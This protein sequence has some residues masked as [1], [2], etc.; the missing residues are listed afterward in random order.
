M[1]IYIRSVHQIFTEILN[2]GNDYYFKGGNSKHCVFKELLGWR[3][4]HELEEHGIVVEY[5]LELI[6]I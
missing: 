3:L 6:P 5:E 4:E 1:K 2:S